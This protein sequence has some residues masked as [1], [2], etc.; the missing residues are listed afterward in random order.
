MNKYLMSKSGQI[1]KIKELFDET[2]NVQKFSGFY[3]DD[4]FIPIINELRYCGNH[5]LS[6]L[7]LDDEKSIDCQ[8]AEAEDHCN[9]AKYDAYECSILKLKT[10]I[11]EFYQVYKDTE[12]CTVIP[13]WIKII[14]L[15][16]EL[17]RFFSRNGKQ[18]IVSSR[19]KS[20]FL[21]NG[22]KRIV[23]NYEVLELSKPE[24]ERKLV[25]I[26][27]KVKRERLLFIIGSILIPII[28]YLLALF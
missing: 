22:L 25:S 17:Q 19:E 2:E 26:R 11:D 12:I 21:E 4:I 18:S 27:T 1:Q 14:K 28:I 3:D 7:N 24:L 8:L 10:K 5:I 23:E 20:E 15:N 13:E 6:A 9:R 16:Q